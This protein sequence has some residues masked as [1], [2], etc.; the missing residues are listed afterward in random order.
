[1]MDLSKQ[2]K[3]NEMIALAQIFCQ[4]PRNSVRHVF[5]ACG[6]RCTLNSPYL[7]SFREFPAQL[8]QRALLPAEAAKRR[9]KWALPVPIP[10]RGS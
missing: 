9:A 10:R 2:L 6:K 8:S 5:E 3:S 7:C 4:Q 1:M